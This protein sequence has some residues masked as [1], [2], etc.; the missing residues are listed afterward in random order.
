MRSAQQADAA[1]RLRRPLIGKTLDGHHEGRIGF[2][3]TAPAV[4]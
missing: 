1:D 2:D 4:M 3:R